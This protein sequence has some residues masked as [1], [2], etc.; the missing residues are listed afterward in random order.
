MENVKKT[1]VRTAKVKIFVLENDP[2]LKKEKYKRL[3][4]I[5][6]NHFKA[7]NYMMT[8]HVMGKQ[9]HSLIYERAGIVDF[10]LPESKRKVAELEDTLYGK[11]GLFGVKRLACTQRDINTKF[12]MIPAGTRNV[13][14][15]LIDKK[16]KALLPDI[17]KGN[18]TVPT[19]KSNMP[20]SLKFANIK[21]LENENGINLKW[22]LS[23]KNIKKGTDKE[24]ITFG[25]SFGK[26]PANNRLT[27]KRL[28]NGELKFGSSQL[29]YDKKKNAW[30]LLLA[31]NQPLMTPVLDENIA[32]GI[33]LGLSTIATMVHTGTKFC[34]AIGSYNDFVRVRVQMQQRR[35]AL[36]QSLKMTKGGKGRKRKLAPLDRLSDK[37]RNFVNSYNHRISK[38]I[39]EY[40]VKN[41][42]AT[43]KLEFLKGYSENEPSSFTLRN[44]SYFELQNMIEYKAQMFGI[45]VKFIDPYHTSKECSSCGFV[46]VELKSTDRE[47]I[48]PEC[49]EKHNRDRNAA[50]NIARSI[51]FVT[52]VEQTQFYKLHKIKEKITA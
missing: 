13:L 25:I 12:N 37:E 39:V 2:E 35:K 45:E 40:A 22:T 11:D 36:Q 42:A 34:Q 6:F 21:I 41:N 5:R 47:W 23:G 1:I 51:N 31:I 27:F 44:W 24:I 7:A 30:Y 15:S 17:T 20:I 43:I 48:C 3:H 28:A 50:I 8:S 32:V 46:H 18:V 4:D 14:N 16:Y 49:K 26:D 52:K 10:D 9:F 19:F 33:D 38:S 29:Y